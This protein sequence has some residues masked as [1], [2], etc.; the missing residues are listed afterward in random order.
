M[1]DNNVEEIRK[2][3]EEIMKILGIE[4]TES[5]ENTPLRVAKMYCNELFRNRG[6]AH[7]EELNNSIKTFQNPNAGNANQNSIHIEDIPFSSTCEHHWLPFYGT[8][9][10]E[11]VPK[12][13]VIGLSKIP[14]VVKYF[15]KKPQLQEQLAKEIGDYLFEVID[16]IYLEVRI[17]AKHCCVMCRGAE[18]DCETVNSYVRVSKDPAVMDVSPNS[19]TFGSF[20]LL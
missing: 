14:R 17:R 13:R 6:N 20:T 19:P 18:S 15:S 5:N 2:H 4:K 16:P 11:Y 10:V 8:V 9:S 1:I 12:D 3:F 7:I